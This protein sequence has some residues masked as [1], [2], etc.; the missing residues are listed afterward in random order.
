MLRP[1]LGPF[2]STV[3]QSEYPIFGGT[4]TTAFM[5]RHRVPQAALPTL[6]WARAE[7]SAAIALAPPAGRRFAKSS[8]VSNRRWVMPPPGFTS[9]KLW[10]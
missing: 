9:R 2:C 8:P 4:A 7:L 3:I 10:S 6:G 5:S 1:R